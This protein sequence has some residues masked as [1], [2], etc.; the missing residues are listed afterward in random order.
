MFQYKQTHAG[1][2]YGP[3]KSDTCCIQKM[4]ILILQLYIATLSVP[5]KKLSKRRYCL[6]VTKLSKSDY[7]KLPVLV[8]TRTQVPC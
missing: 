1:I 7:C 5:G 3:Y 2:M 8:H 6:A 4:L